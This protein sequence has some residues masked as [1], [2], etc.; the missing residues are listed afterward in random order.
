MNELS[1]LQEWYL[2]Q[3]DGE[4]E[5]DHGITIGSLDN[6]GWI[7]SISLV[8][9]DLQG[10][11][12]AELSDLSPRHDWYRCWVEDGKWHAAGGPLMLARLLRHFLDWAA[13]NRLR[14]T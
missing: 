14:A 11:T 12:F 7:V 4:W 8:D 9:T 5:H 13:T 1:E 2:S 10:L 6:P 3:C